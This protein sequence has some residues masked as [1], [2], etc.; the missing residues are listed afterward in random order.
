MS[1]DRL[2]GRTDRSIEKPTLFQ[3]KG[4]GGYEG[5]LERSR[6]SRFLIVNAHPDD[7]FPAA[8]LVQRLKGEYGMTPELALFTMGEG[9]EDARTTRIISQS[10]MFSVRRAEL[11][12]AAEVMGVERVHYFSE[13]DGGLKPRLDLAHGLAKVIREVKPALMIIPSGDHREHPD[14]KAVFELS[15]MARSMAALPLDIEESK[16]PHT[17]PLLVEDEVMNVNPDRFPHVIDVTGQAAL[18]EAHR[19]AYGSQMGG[20]KRYEVFF[21]SKRAYAGARLE[22][23]TGLGEAFK[24]S[25]GEFKPEDLLPPGYHPIGPVA[26]PLLLRV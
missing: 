9:G 26:N 16:S 21:T 3:G 14:H 4:A 12:Q 18:I 15:N 25:N 7:E 22:V 5:V 2:Y 19:L 17:V 8:G 11:A 13:P 10:N 6:G 20:S 1:A 23:A 24:V